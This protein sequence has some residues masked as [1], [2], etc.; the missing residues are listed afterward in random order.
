MSL[1]IAIFFYYG[2]EYD[3][4]SDMIHL[5]FVFPSGAHEFTTCF[6]VVRVALSSVLC[7]LVCRSL[8]VPFR[9]AIVL[10]V[11]R[12]TASYYPLVYANT[13]Y[14]SCLMTIY[15]CISVIR[16]VCQYRC[17]IVKN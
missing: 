14:V 9:L 15:K 2:F 16:S 6:S 10:S 3:I 13:S 12:F 4:I 1:N 8:F 11:L 5:M 7:A 17:K